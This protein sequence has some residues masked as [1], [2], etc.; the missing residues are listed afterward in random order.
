MKVGSVF[1]GILGLDWAVCEHYGAELSFVVEKNAFCREL[2]AK[3]YPNVAIYDDLLKVSPHNL[4]PVDILAGSPPCQDISYSGRHAGLVEGERSSLF[5]DFMALA[6]SLA[7]KV[8]VMEN[9]P[10][11]IRKYRG[12][13]EKESK[14]A[15]YGCTFVLCTARCVGAP[16]IRERAF[17]VCK[18]DQPH[19][20]LIKH[21]L[22][23]DDFLWPTPMASDYRSRGGPGSKAVENRI[24]KGK[25]LSLS[26]RAGCPLN[27]E[28]VEILMGFPPG[29]TDINEDNA[30]RYVSEDH[31]WPGKIDR[32]F[33]WEP[34]RIGENNNQITQ[35]RLKALGNAVCP[36][37][38]LHALRLAEIGPVQMELII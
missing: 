18:R 15:G 1:S 20:G 34:P 33:P 4:T 2:V 5:F 17:V 38:A 7:P 9:T 21:N 14:N 16:H 24:K 27:P 3:R 35:Q 30:W 23:T 26:M 13:V 22:S 11:F 25:Q 8:V 29:Y 10:A 36:Q 12:I 37:Q 6:R 28:F 31:C 19:S 32:S